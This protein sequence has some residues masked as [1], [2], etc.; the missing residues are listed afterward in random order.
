ME[1]SAVMVIHKYLICPKTKEND[2]QIYLYTTEEK[3]HDN[4]TDKIVHI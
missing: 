4:H 1:F 2:S 3:K